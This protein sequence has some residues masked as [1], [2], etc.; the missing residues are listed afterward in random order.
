MSGRW[1]P[2]KNIEVFGSIQNL[3]DK[4]APLDPTTYG[5][6]NFNPLHLSGAIGRYYTVGLKYKF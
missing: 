3:L 6:V 2:T 1:S 5:A 4:I